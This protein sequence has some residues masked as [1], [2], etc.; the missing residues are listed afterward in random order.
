MSHLTEEQLVLHYYG[1]EGET[2]AIEGH[3]EECGECRVLYGS[4]Q[5]TLNSMDTMP[6]P[7]RGAEYGEQVWRQIEGKLPQRRWWQIPIGRTPAVRWAFSGT[8]LTAL[9]ALAFL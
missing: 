9:L 3:L 7:E 8:A 2:L 5:R 6:V 1:E 4:L